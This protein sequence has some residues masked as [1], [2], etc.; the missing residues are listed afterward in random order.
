M[1]QVLKEIT[2][3]N[4]IPFIVSENDKG[5]SQNLIKWKIR[6][7]TATRFFQNFIDK[8]DVVIDIGANLGYYAIQEAYKAKK[9]YA[10][11]PIKESYEILLKNIALNKLTNVESFE[12]AIG[13]KTGDLK[14]YVGDSLNLASVHKTPDKHE[15]TVPMYSG[16]DF[17]EKLTEQP[18]VLRMDVEGYELKIAKSFRE[19]LK[20]FDKVFIE[21]HHCVFHDEGTHELLDLLK[22]NGFTK[23]YT[24]LSNPIK[25]PNKENVIEEGYISLDEFRN[26][27]DYFHVTY[28]FA[29]K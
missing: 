6:E 28:M 19:K 7:G 16:H 23:L 26:R 10:I 11:E 14:L 3:F 13:D 17:L 2:L 21:V 4:G 18:N 8:N 15:V 5:L 20:Q 24:I 27:K 25:L 12:C 9:V 1:E 29:F 22:E